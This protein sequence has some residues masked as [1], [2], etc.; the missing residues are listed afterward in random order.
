M[1]KHFI[2]FYFYENLKFLS[3]NEIWYHWKHRDIH[4]SLKKKKKLLYFSVNIK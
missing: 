2:H 1:R 4:F 3:L